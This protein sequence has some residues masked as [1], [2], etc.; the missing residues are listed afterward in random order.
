MLTILMLGDVVG[1]IG[2][3][4]LRA[5]LPRMRRDYNA[6]LVVANGENAAEGNGLLPKTAEHL[7]DSGVDVITSGNH[8][9]RRREIYDMLDEGRGLLRPANYSLRSPGHGVF[10]F[11][12]LKA[13]VTVVNLMGALY[14]Q[15]ACN[16]FDAVDEVLAKLDT[17]IVLVDFHA[18][19]TSEKRA[20]GFY[21]D[22]RVSAV[23]GTHTHVQT[24]DDQILPGGTGYI[25]DLGMCGPHQSVLGVQTDAVIE[26]FRSSLPTRFSNAAGECEIS[27]I[28]VEIDETTGKTSA[29]ER[30][31]LLVP[32]PVR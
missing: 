29:I 20:M 2:C 12:S 24:A 14:M 30:I 26:R 22:G 25:T 13:R 32:E 16:P 23:A 11:D 21:L 19:L 1:E 6:F 28:A 17:K 8:I 18:E 10:V 4:A 7:F 3:A 9:F 27:G 31:S 5:H 15:P